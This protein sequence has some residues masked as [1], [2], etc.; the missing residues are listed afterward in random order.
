MGFSE[1]EVGQMSYFKWEKLY[2]HFKD[3]HNFETKKLIFESKEAESQSDI[4]N[5]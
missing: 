5:F 1:K 2:K 4:A 3:M